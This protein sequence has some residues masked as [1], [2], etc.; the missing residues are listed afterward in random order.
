MG[1]VGPSAGLRHDGVQKTKVS[2][3]WLF[4]VFTF[5][6]KNVLDKRTREAKWHKARPIAPDI[7][8]PMRVMLHKAGRAWFK[9]ADKQYGDEFIM[10]KIADVP[11]T[12]QKLTKVAFGILCSSRDDQARYPH[13][14]RIYGSRSQRECA[15]R[16]KQPQRLRS[17]S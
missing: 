7:R 11:N 4:M 10:P 1:A 17:R 9:I 8:H 5:K 3:S 2:P 15:A 13:L 12:L 14:Y 6:A 16:S